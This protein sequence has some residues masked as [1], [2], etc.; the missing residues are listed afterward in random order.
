MA[1]FRSQY[2]LETL[3]DTLR[4]ASIFGR[5]LPGPDQLQQ[6]SVAEVFCAVL[7]D[8]SVGESTFT[9]QENIA[10]LK[11]CFQEGW[12]HATEDDYHTRYIFPTQLHFWFVEYYLGTRLMDPSFI[13]TDTLRQFAVK[14]IK[15][16]SP[17]SLTAPRKIGTAEQRRPEAQYQDEWYR[18]CHTLTKGSLISFPEFGNGS[19]RINFYIPIKKWG[20]ELL[21]DGHDI[22]GHLSRFEGS[23]AYASFDLDDYIVLDFRTTEPQ[24]THDSGG[25]DILNIFKLPLT[26]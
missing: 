4:T 19:G 20:V 21:H 25:F 26:P 15:L 1:T 2:R 22:Q 14:V 6:P 10:A 3:W 18:C 24:E 7:R 9:S 23:D 12:L 5:G 13:T 8:K 17:Q 16:F 11:Q